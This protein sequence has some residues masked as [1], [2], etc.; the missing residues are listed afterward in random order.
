MLFLILFFELLTA[1]KTEDKSDGEI[2][3]DFVFLY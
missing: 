3:S 2:S 1:G